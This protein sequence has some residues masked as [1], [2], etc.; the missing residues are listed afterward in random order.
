MTQTTRLS[1]KGQVV[2]PADVRRA[3]GLKPGQTLQ[4]RT[5]AG[6]I[7]LT[8]LV[9]KSGRST[10]EILASLEKIYTHEG[11]PVPLEEM[12]AAVDAMI[13]DRAGR[14]EL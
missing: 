12:S 14:G 8:P 3:L 9:Q 7:M 5:A 13:K 2:I 4:V 6:G 1:G 11:P 10:G